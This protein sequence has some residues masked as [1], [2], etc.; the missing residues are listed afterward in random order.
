MLTSAA[1]V[2]ATLPAGAMILPL[3]KMRKSELRP[4]AACGSKLSCAPGAIVRAESDLVTPTSAV[5]VVLRVRFSGC[6]RYAGSSVAMVSD[7][8]DVPLGR[9]AMAPGSRLRFFWL[10]ARST[11]CSTVR[12]PR[13]EVSLT[14][15]KPSSV[16][17]D[18][19]SRIAPGLEHEML[20][21]HRVGSASDRLPPEANA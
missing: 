2:S 1:I 13:L 14:V 12:L 6:R 5:D 4:T 20:E 10:T 19:A 8:K 7:S 3:A 21:M 17:S 9:V 11:S 18:G 16:N 15:P